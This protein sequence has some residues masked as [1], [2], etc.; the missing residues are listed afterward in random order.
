M[1]LVLLTDYTRSAS[2]WIQT[3]GCRREDLPYLTRPADLTWARAEEEE[4]S[5]SSCSFD[6][7][8]C[9]EGTLDMSLPITRRD[10]L[11]LDVDG[12]PRSRDPEFAA[13][14]VLAAA[15]EHFQPLPLIP[16]ISR[17]PD[18]HTAVSQKHSRKPHHKRR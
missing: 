4:S 15:L 14:L 13:L 3:S 16:H 8:D 9:G 6:F 18:L 2:G 17:L 1:S 10:H 12:F 7:G 11:D 5:T